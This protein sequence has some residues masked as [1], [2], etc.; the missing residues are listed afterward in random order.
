VA[1]SNRYDLFPCRFQL[2]AT[3]GGAWT[4]ARF[5]VDLIQRGV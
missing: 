1:E 5:A 2:I 3:E 4:A